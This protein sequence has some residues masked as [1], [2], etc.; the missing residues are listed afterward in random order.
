MSKKSRLFIRPQK[1]N[2]GDKVGVVAPAGPVNKEQLEKVK[3]L[4]DLYQSD[5]SEKI[6]IYIHNNYENL[7]NI[8]S[9]SIKETLYVILN[10]LDNKNNLNSE[11]FFDKVLDQ[12]A[13]PTIFLNSQIET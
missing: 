4:Y 12:R 2:P 6:L 9:V 11:I 8:E 13:M 1:L 7:I 10:V 5:D 3:L